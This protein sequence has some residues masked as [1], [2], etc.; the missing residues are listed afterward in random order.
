[1]FLR[2]QF[3]AQYRCLENI[4]ELYLSHNNLT[5]IDFVGDN[6]LHSLYK[7]TTLT[8]IDVSNNNIL[9]LPL[10][11]K[12]M[13][14]LTDLNLKDNTNLL[15]G[16]SAHIDKIIKESKYYTEENKLNIKA[17]QKLNKILYIDI[18]LPQ[19]LKTLLLPYLDEKLQKDLEDASKALTTLPKPQYLMKN[20]TINKNPQTN[21][22]TTPTP[23]F[24]YGQGQPLN[25][26]F[27]FG[28]F[29]PTYKSSQ[30]GG[31]NKKINH[32]K[33]NYINRNKKNLNVNQKKY[34]TRTI[35]ISN[36]SI[37]KI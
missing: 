7:L 37:K 25:N 36:K 21:P 9:Y 19:N 3:S 16:T 22:T 14:Q 33:I 13:T 4:K 20:T 6:T 8:K 2:Q 30:T 26:S 18:R 29:K 5:N 35:K 27:G 15:L 1:M 12:N 34:K 10:V 11:L 17:A 24:V 32:T 23:V 28:N 31:Y